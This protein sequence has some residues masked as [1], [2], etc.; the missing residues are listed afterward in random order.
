MRGDLELERRWQAANV[1]RA[2]RATGH[3]KD[4]ALARLISDG[5]KAQFDAMRRI[6]ARLDAAQRA[7]G[8]VA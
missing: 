8:G 6:D 3:P 4:L 5:T 2:A 1:W 7:R